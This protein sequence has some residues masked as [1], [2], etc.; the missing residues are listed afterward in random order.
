[1]SKLR[2]FI[3]TGLLAASVAPLYGCGNECGPGTAEKDGQ[4][5]L[6]AKGCGENT[7]LENKQCVV[8][9]TGC[10]EGTV[11][12]NGYC[13]PAEASCAEGTSFDQGSG[14]CVPNTDIVCGEGTE[15]NAEGI[16]VPAAEACA[17]KT[18]LENGVCVIEAA[19]CGS[20]TELDPNTGDCALADAACGDGTALDGDTGACVPTAQVC[21][22]GTKFDADSGLCLPD[23]C[24]EGD[25]LVNNVCMSPAEE[26]AANADLT[27]T[28]PN[29]PAFDGGTAGT[30]T[31]NAVDGDPF[32][33][34]GTIG[35]P[36]DLDGDGE[37]DQD[38]DVFEFDATAGDWFELMVQST[39]L[40][41]PA[42]V[43]EGPNGE[44]MRWS[45]VTSGAATARDL[46]IPADGTYTVTVLPALNLT[47]EEVGP[48]GS[49]DWGYV[50]TLKAVSGG[51]ASD[52][53]ISGGSVQLTGELTDLHDNLFNMANIAPTDVVTFTVDG[54]GEDAQGV[55]QV[56]GDATTLH[57]SQPISA[58]QSV[59]VGVPESGSMLA[60]VDWTMVDGPRV[61]FD[62]SA[63]VTGAQQTVTVPAGGTGTMT[64]SAGLFDLLEINQTNAAA[65]SLDLSITDPN[66]T[67]VATTTLDDGELF[68]HIA[69]NTGGDYVLTLTNNSGSSVDATLGVNISSP[70]DLGQVPT[71][72]SVSSTPVNMLEDDVR[73]YSM[74]LN[75]DELLEVLHDNAESDAVE[76]ELFD[77]TGEVVDSDTYFYAASSTS[78]EFVYARTAGSSSSFLARI[79]TDNGDATDQ[80]ITANSRNYEALGLLPTNTQT[81]TSAVSSLAEDQKAIYT[82]TVAAGEVFA[83]SQTNDADEEIDFD[84]IDSTGTEVMSDTFVDVTN[85]SGYDNYDFEWYW[86]KTETT[87]TLEVAATTDMTNLAVTLHSIT[88]S[89]MGTLDE[90]ASLSITGGAIA[91]GQ[92]GFHT[93]TT[94]GPTVFSGQVVPAAGE[95]VDFYI[96]DSSSSQIVGE[97][98]SGGAVS[99]GGGITTAETFMVR[100]EADEAVTGYDVTLNGSPRVVDLGVL[101][102]DQTTTHSMA[103]F[104]DNQPLTLQFQVPAGQII[105]IY[106][107]NDSSDDHDFELFDANGTS[108]D[109]ESSF[110]PLSYSNPEYIYYYTDA[111]G[112]F[113]LEIEGKDGVSNE[114]ISIN[115]YTPQA[116]G[117]FAQGN[118]Q[119]VTGPAL[120]ENQRLYYLASFSEDGNL[121]IT[122]TSGNSEDIDLRIFDKAYTSLVNETAT[123][124]ITLFR[125]YTSAGE[126]LVA[127][128]GDDTPSSFDLTIELQTPL[129]PP[130]FGS[131]PA[132]AIPNDET[133][134][135]SDTVSVTNC[136]TV[137]SVEAFVDITHS[138][139]G[140]L[141]IT[142]TAPD[143]TT[144]VLLEE[145]TGLD[146]DDFVTG[147]YPAEKTPVGDLA[148]FSGLTGDGT[149]TLT[150]FDEYDWF[151]YPSSS[152]GDDEGTLN[153]WG[154][155]LVCQ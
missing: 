55:L 133:T 50:G 46:V 96:Y 25:V 23:S 19:A 15:A 29:D 30:L 24:G 103:T 94:T 21:D 118:S 2:L 127:V 135:V 112:S 145:Y 22:T 74:S 110:Y 123:G 43:V 67:E 71:G 82:F 57:E 51:T 41:A 61:D 99:V 84:L 53:D 7:L 59:T 117:P 134:S 66:G 28:E 18:V 85:D 121:S 27:E 33:F 34:A 9:E 79:V 150:I 48:S 90:T 63:E 107:E 130:D 39:G 104:G 60:L 149:W 70:T 100:I 16:C 98:G 11:L 108:L 37:V 32:V 75:A 56:W 143:G 124:G 155:T 36:T 69:F 91:D 141:T 86:V 136:A 65:E 125:P 138:Q 128:E 14:T 151:S 47:S 139:L 153:E 154:L 40:P 88:P 49:D 120:L 81:P 146:S 44:Y 6:V 132:L 102:A 45:P 80:V 113:E 4:C 114:V 8:N 12:E 115:L 147:W 31:V 38:V 101:P 17:D 129:P 140:D 111:G 122:G 77:I 83:I 72:G 68:E 26:L 78:G 64:V 89:D 148:T 95:D 97:T 35:A 3:L 119:T 116:L 152:E 54:I 13:V 126:Y 73:Y 137:S 58:G 5:V 105:E 93:F 1:M 76:I 10:D 20:G 109:N 142:L 62:I 87:F 42:F 92:S 52:Q 106:H 131:T 144:S